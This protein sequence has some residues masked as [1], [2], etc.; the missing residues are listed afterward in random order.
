MSL[1]RSL[2]ALTSHGQMLSTAESKVTLL[3]YLN[4]FIH[5]FPYAIPS[6]DRW[7]HQTVGEQ[8]LCGHDFAIFGLS[9]TCTLRYELWTLRIQI[10]M[11][12]DA[13]RPT[14]CT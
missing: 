2:V 7:L 6:H 1:I 14:L 3:C 12:A 13:G 8:A 4:K 9:L 10:G 5:V 11:E